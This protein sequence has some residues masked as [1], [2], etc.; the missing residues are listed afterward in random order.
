MSSKQPAIELRGIGLR[1]GQKWILQGI[2]WT[3]QAGRCAAVLGPNGS[4]KSTLA[5][6]LATHV[7]P[8]EGECRVLGGEF[9]GVDL[10][11][12]R[13]SIR[14]VQP[15]GPYDIALELTAR[16]VVL[17][18]FFGSLGLYDVPTQAMVDEADGVLGQIGLQELAEH[19]YGTLSSGERVRCL[20]GRAL[21]RRPRL[22]ILDEPTAG[23]D[24]RAR[25]QVLGTI[26]AMFERNG[27][28]PTLVLITHHVEELP[29]ATS[30]VL[31][32]S[33]GRLA[34]LGT[35][36]EVLRS[37]VLSRVYGC[38]VDVHETAGRFHL[39]VNPAV[40]AQLLRREQA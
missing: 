27:N 24:L 30:E 23:L 11:E 3:L 18:G 17:T 4:G 33:D 7:W 8:T 28:P 35:P 15:A 19:A 12:V 20:I 25:E 14:L 37:E 9:G 10:S 34:A 22:L 1:R 36:R 40:W 29:P 5:R 2:D 31:L 13:H 38:P 21:V 39:H 32:L 6:I 26:Q 16:A